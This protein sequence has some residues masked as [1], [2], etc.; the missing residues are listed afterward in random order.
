MLGQNASEA[1]G[2]SQTLR[3]IVSDTGPLLSVFQSE[4]VELLQ[5]LFD[6][7]YIPQSTLPEFV[8]HNAAASINKLIKSRFVLVCELNEQEVISARG[9]SEEIAAH[10]LTKDKLSLSHYPE[11]EAMVLV[12]R[13]ELEVNEIL[14]D[15]RAARAIA[16]AHGLAV[17]G[18][19][20]LLIRA[21][22]TRQIT[23][24]EARDSL[25]KCVSFGTH[26]SQSLIKEIYNR[27][28]QE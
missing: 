3:C 14:L 8:K 19:P 25:I 6:R 23:P 1:M 10:S 12:N 21:C 9:L 4:Q 13:S 28:K 5:F 18:F 20:G 17:I 11:A 7:I 16:R 2:S 15:E 27:L 22:R 24:E 26:Y